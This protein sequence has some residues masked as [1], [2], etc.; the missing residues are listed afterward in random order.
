MKNIRKIMMAYAIACIVLAGCG[1][2]TQQAAEPAAEE[3]VEAATEKAVEAA[4]EK[5]VEAATEK[6]VEAATEK[7]VE[8]AAEEAAETAAEE[9]VDPVAEEAVDPAPGEAVDSDPEKVIGA[10]AEAAKQ[11]ANAAEDNSGWNN[12][13]KTKIDF[14]KQEIIY[15]DGVVIHYEINGEE[16][17]FTMD[18]KSLTVTGHPE[19]DPSSDG[20]WRNYLHMARLIIK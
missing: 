11:G 6:A 8:P 13:D 4:T 14:E 17:T 15:S 9:T 10:L 19:G 5:A 18:G 2:K 16:A 12:P 7:A 3:T 1:S 20:K